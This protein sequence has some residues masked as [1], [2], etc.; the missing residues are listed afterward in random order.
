MAFGQKTFYNFSQGHGHTIDLWGIGFC[1]NSNAQ[2]HR[3]R[4]QRLKEDFVSIFHMSKINKNDVFLMT[5][6]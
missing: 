4:S 3:H 2:V 5:F 1:D 6:L